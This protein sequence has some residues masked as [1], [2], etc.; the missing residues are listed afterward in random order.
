M[1][2][3]APSRFRLKGQHSLALSTRMIMSC[4]HNLD[5]ALASEKITCLLE[6]NSV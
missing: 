5:D 1:L 2:C 3:N 4:D 6:G